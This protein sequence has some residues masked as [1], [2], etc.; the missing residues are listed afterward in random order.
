MSKENYENFSDCPLN[1]VRNI[2][3]MQK[4]THIHIP[5]YVHKIKQDDGKGR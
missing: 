4:K 1:P 3:F 2:E 5:R